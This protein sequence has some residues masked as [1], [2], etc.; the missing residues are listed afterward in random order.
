M[1][2]SGVSSS[3]A[4]AP[5][6]FM[7]GSPPFGPQRL[8]TLDHH[9]QDGPANRWSYQ[10][11]RELIPTA[12]ITRGSGPAWRLP[13]AEIDLTGVEVPVAGEVRRVGHVLDATQTDGFL[14]LHRGEIVTELYFNDMAEDTP[15]LL[16][17]VSKSITGAVAGCLVGRGVLDVSARLGDV[18][19]ELS[20]TSFGDATVQQILDMRTGTRF[21]EDYGNIDA[22]I[23]DCEQVYGWRPRIDPTLPRDAL[24]YFATL[25]NDTEHGGPF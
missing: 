7:T 21:N 18:V 6:G 11:V 19:A 25:P 22:D 2:P 1:A 20:A 10:H 16:Q 4:S 23:S 13:R 17:S 3:D 8:V 24:S 15:H 12:R 5:P 14:V 9:W